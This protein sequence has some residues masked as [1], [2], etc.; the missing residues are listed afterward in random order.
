MDKDAGIHKD[1][2]K[3]KRKD[4]DDGDDSSDS[5]VSDGMSAQTKNSGNSFFDPPLENYR[6]YYQGDG[7][8]GS[9]LGG[10][11]SFGGSLSGSIG[12]KSDNRAVGLVLK[13]KQ[14]SSFR[15]ID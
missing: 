3:D 1:Q 7:G 5:S 14:H 8:N 2:L 13:K 6:F 12:R 9:R 4:K 15:H 10:Y 11:K